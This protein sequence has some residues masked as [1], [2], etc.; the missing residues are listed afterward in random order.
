MKHYCTLLL[1]GG[2]FLLSCKTDPPKDD[3]ARLEEALDTQPTKENAQ[4]LIKAISEK[5]SG[6]DKSDPSM[7]SLLEKGLKI[8]SVHNLT[9]SKVSFLMPLIRQ[10]SDDDSTTDRLLDLADVM[11]SSKK[12][13]I[14]DVI[15]K[16]LSDRFPE[17]ENINTALGKMRAPIESLDA[18]L[19]SMGEVIFENPDQFGINR[20]S[21][22]AYV[23]ACEAYALANPGNVKSAEYLYKAAEIAR[24]LRTF[25]KALSIYDWIIDSYPEYDKAPTTLF[26]KGF[27]VENELKNDD[28]AR[29]V[30]NTFLEKYPAHDL[31]DD[32]KFLLEN[33]GKS[34]EEILE[35][36]ENNKK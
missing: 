9:G 25:P 18:K 19:V 32:V 24:S 7:K 20:R 23:D 27:I 34:N 2:L 14:S 31:A 30:Y 15:I 1:L 12:P 13:H 5:I 17:D 33:L 21:S 6:L 8:S 28:M 3:I 22:Q 4:A 11:S 29:E 16:S 10:Y 36:I 26:L 35:L